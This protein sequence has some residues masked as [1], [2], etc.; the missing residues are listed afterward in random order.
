MMPA[1]LFNTLVTE[2]EPYLAKHFLA[3]PVPHASWDRALI[4]PWLHV[5]TEPLATLADERRLTFEIGPGETPADAAARIKAFVAATLAQEPT[6]RQAAVTWT[7]TAPGRAAAPNDR[8]ASSLWDEIWAKSGLTGPVQSIWDGMARLPWSDAALATALAG[9]IHWRLT[10]DNLSAGRAMHGRELEFA[11][12]KALLAAPVRVEIG[13]LGNAHN[14]A[15]LPEGELLAAIRDDF[16]SLIRPEDRAQIVG[17]S[18]N[19]MMVART[20]ALLFDFGRLAAAFASV[21]IPSQAVFG[22]QL[23]LF[24]NPAR[25]RVIGPS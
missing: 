20:P 16:P 3:P 17:H 13:G 10:A 14:W 6:L 8:P 23:P 11:T 18:F 24:D 21:M 22:P 5:R 7:V 12:A 19:S 15:W 25:A 9:A 1:G 2:G 4:E